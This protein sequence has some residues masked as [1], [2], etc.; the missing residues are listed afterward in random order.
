[1][2]G[3]EPIDSNSLDEVMSENELKEWTQLNEA[4]FTGEGWNKDDEL[5]NKLNELR[6]EELNAKKKRIRERDDHLS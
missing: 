4:Q 6:L 5:R 1:M 3:L 2:E